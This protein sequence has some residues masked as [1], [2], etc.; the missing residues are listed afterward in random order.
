MRIFIHGNDRGNAVL[1][2]L[3]LIIILSTVFITFVPRIT[4][5]NSFSRQYKERV[6]HAIEKENREIRERYDLY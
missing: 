2:A 6:I 5:I 1:A 3:V 4:A